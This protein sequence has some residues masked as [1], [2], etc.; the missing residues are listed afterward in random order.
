MKVIQA[1][2]HSDLRKEGQIYQVSD[3]VEQNLTILEDG[4]VRLDAI[5]HEGL[6]CWQEEKEIEKEVCRDIL[7]M[8]DEYANHPSDN[9]QE[10]TGKW[11]MTLVYEDGSEV[12]LTG[13]MI[14][15]VFAGDVDLT[16]YIREH[17]P[18]MSLGVF[19]TTEAL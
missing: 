7:S 10:N 15:K 1:K 9:E 13:P 17:M 11:E 14:G 19:D 16:E 3:E 2:I 18:F 6:P 4:T 12:N 8:L 5:S